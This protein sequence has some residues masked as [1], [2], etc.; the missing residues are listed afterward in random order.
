ME[1]AYWLQCCE[2]NQIG[3]HKE[4]PSEFLITLFPALGLS[5]GGRIF[6]PLCGKTLAMHWLRA[7]GCE[8]IGVELR[9]LAVMQFFA[10]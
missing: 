1:Q 2:N 10:A 9:A 8:V 3:L 6:V 7:Q 4:A 5:P